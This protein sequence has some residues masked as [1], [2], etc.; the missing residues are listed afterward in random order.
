MVEVSY[1]SRPS[2]RTESVSHVSPVSA[3]G[4]DKSHHLPVNTHGIIRNAR[5]PSISNGSS[6]H[7]GDIEDAGAFARSDR[8]ATTQQS[9]THADSPTPLQE[10]QGAASAPIVAEKEGQRPNIA[11]RFYKQCQKIL[12]SSWINV[13]LVFVPVGIAVQIGG[14]NKNIIFAMN[15]I[16]IVPLAGLLSHATESVASEMGDTIG[17]LMNVTFGNAVELII[18]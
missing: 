1:E 7:G 18:L 3:L 9:I 13:L 6:H 8:S 10:D 5:L 16:A 11:L 14:A 17:S 12:F 2:D 15:A 4:R